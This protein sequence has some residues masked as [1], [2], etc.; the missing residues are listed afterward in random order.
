[1]RLVFQDLDPEAACASGRLQ[2]EG[3]TEQVIRF[4]RSLGLGG[5]RA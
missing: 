3:D 5:Q 4:F 2:I 1:M